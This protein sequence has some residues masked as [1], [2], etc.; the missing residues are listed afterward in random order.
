MVTGKYSRKGS[1]LVIKIERRKIK[2]RFLNDR[3]E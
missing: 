3:L 1:R 2:G